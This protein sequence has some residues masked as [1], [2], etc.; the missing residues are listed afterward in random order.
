MKNIEVEYLSIRSI[1]KVPLT[2]NDRS[3]NQERMEKS[4]TSSLPQANQLSISQ[5]DRISA[6]RRLR[7]RTSWRS[8]DEGLVA[9]W[10]LVWEVEVVVE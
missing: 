2:L 4:R 9:A 1:W 7:S 6:A 10:A 3:V 5:L 8:G